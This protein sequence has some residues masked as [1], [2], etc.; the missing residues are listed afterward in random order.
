MYRY[1]GK[2]HSAAMS[3]LNMCLEEY[4]EFL[5]NHPHITIY[6]DGALVYE[7]VRIKGAGSNT[8][9]A[10]PVPNPASGYQASL[11]NMDGVVM[12]YSYK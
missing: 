10:L 8:S 1:V 5:A 6:E 2:A 11:D 9:F 3:V 12:A 4:I 7:V